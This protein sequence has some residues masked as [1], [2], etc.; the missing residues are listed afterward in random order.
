M[1]HKMCAC[2]TCIVTCTVTQTKEAYDSQQKPKGHIVLAG[3]KGICVHA[4]G[5]CLCGVV[6][7]CVCLCVCGYVCVCV[8][9]CVHIPT[10]ARARTHTHAHTHA[11]THTH[12]HTK[13]GICLLH[14]LPRAPANGGVCV[15]VCVVIQLDGC[16]QHQS[17]IASSSLNTSENS[18]S[19][20]PCH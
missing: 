14:T 19:S 11:R 20:L 3:C 17:A 10:H 5:W 7:L 9:V 8:C 16:V 15:C 12:T 2:A 4:N 13:V 18:L 1:R 6:C